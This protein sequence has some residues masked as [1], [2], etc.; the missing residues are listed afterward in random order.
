MRDVVQIAARLEDVV[1]AAAQEHVLIVAAEVFAVTVE[2]VRRVATSDE[3]A[4]QR[5]IAEVLILLELGRVPGLLIVVDAA[6]GRGTLDAHRVVV[7]LSERRPCGEEAGDH[8]GKQLLAHDLL[9]TV[10]A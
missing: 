7:G 1:D 9:L 2:P 8:G 5:T 6:E 3:N 10:S 4:R